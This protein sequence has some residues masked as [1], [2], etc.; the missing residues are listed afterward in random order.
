MPFKSKQQAKLMFAAAASPKVAKA[1]GVPQS[2]AKKMVKEGQKSL[3]KL[4]KLVKKK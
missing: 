3:K 4:P 1:T 2:V